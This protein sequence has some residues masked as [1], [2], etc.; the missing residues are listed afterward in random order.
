MISFNG[1]EEENNFFIFL[2]K[3]SVI[4]IFLGKIITQKYQGQNIS[5]F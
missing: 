4:D 2:K 5:N 1:E 3:T